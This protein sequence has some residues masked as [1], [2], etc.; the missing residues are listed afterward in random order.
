MLYGGW[1]FT[2]Y[3]VTERSSGSEVVFE[4]EDGETTRILDFISGRNDLSRTDK[5]LLARNVMRFYWKLDNKANSLNFEKA[6]EQELKKVCL[7]DD[8]CSDVVALGEALHPERE[9][10]EHLI[11][12]LHDYDKDLYMAVWRIETET[13]NPKVRWGKYVGRR[14]EG[15]VSNIRFEAATNTIYLPLPTWNSRG[16][17]LVDDFVSEASHSK[18]LNDR[19]TIFFINS[20]R[21]MIEVE[22]YAYKYHEAYD[23]AYDEL[24]YDEPGTI[25]YEAHKIIQPELKKSIPEPKVQPQK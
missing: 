15:G 19:P 3:K 12:P 18:Q 16:G 8:L 21:D 5:L 14:G 13:G 23:D 20:L 11:M 4:H 17:F 9:W 6:E 1:T 7:L 24:L 22:I 25:E 10:F 2:R